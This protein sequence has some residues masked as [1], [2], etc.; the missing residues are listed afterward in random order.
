[1]RKIRPSA[2]ITAPKVWKIARMAPRVPETMPLSPCHIRDQLPVNSPMKTF[3]TPPS[4]LQRFRRIVSTPFMAVDTTGANT[5]FRVDQI[6]LIFSTPA[7]KSDW[8]PRHIDV[9]NPPVAD[10]PDF[11]PDHADLKALTN[12]PLN[13]FVVAEASDLIPSHAPV[14]KFPK[15]ESPDLIPS[16]APVKKLTNGPENQ[17]PTA[18]ATSFTP[19]KAP[20]T[21]FRN[22]SECL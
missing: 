4:T 14:K 19:F 22:F 17:R 6:A 2:T 10:A 3:R 20:F 18:S 5:A 16:H 11:T 1:M 7:V 8:I 9:K 21:P 12:G 13:Q 15:A